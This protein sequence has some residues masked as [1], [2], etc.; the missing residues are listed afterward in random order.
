MIP[1]EELESVHSSSDYR[2][3]VIADRCDR[4]GARALI[5]AHRGD[6]ELLFC[7][8]HGEKHFEALTDQGYMYQD[9]TSRI[10]SEEA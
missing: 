9:E 7:G 10:M 5:R 8:H 2:Q 1:V 3:L 6:G 4:C